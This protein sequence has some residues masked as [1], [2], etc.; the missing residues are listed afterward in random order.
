M[1]PC[2]MVRI[3]KCRGTVTRLGMTKLQLE[4]SVLMDTV[5][6]SDLI[7]AYWNKVMAVVI[8]YYKYTYLSW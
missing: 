2:E 7:N 1:V 4:R 5:L 8:K 3:V 6:L